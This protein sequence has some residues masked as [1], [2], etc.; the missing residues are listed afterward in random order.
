M[1]R[2]R[3]NRG[4][5][6][7][8]AYV[9]A[10]EVTQ[11]LSHA[12]GRERALTHFRANQISRAYLDCLRTGHIP[13]EDVL[14]AARD[15]LTANG[16]DVAAGLTP[17]RG[18]G[19]GSTHGRHWLCYT[20]DD[21]RRELADVS[22]ATA[23]LFDRIIVDDFLCTQ[24]QCAE[25]RDERGGR[26]WEEFY[27]QLMAEVAREC[28]IDPIKSENPDA[29]VIIKY[30]QWYD[31]FHNFGYDVTRHPTSFDEVWAGTEIRDT[32]VEY[33]VQYQAFANHT[34]LGSL[35]GERMGGAWFD[36]INC[37][38]E[39][40]VE[41]AVQSILAG[42]REL[43]RFHYGPDLY[44]PDSACTAALIEAIPAL[45]ALADELD[46]REPEGVLFYKPPMSDAG[47]EAYLADY[48]GMLGLPIV[49]T[50]VLPRTAEAVCFAAQAAGDPEA[51]T[52]ALALAEGGATVLLT[53]GFIRR[54]A[55]DTRVLE[56]AGLA[57]PGVSPCDVWTYQFAVEGQA[58]SGEQHVRFASRLLPT[59]AEAPATAIH[60][61]GPVAVLTRHAVGQGQVVVLNA[62]TFDYPP[63]SGR[64]T[65]AAPV[66]L[67]GLP[68][69]IVDRLRALTL[70]G[71]NFDVD[72]RSKVGVFRYGDR[73][74]LANFND[75]DVEA[76]VRGVTAGSLL[77][78]P[79]SPENAPADLDG[80]GGTRVPRR[81][82]VLLATDE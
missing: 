28:F 44:E 48:L 39:M 14:V 34:W 12:E 42:A 4:P 35:S 18:S 9:P 1:D 71:T 56:M 8:S 50:H 3:G 36:F 69:P 61:D 72:V 29:T 82:F 79:A 65:S 19:R 10:H 67:T 60:P 20:S 33:V 30:P 57:Y 75:Q 66:S 31:R 80:G 53:P 25:C 55:H 16:I 74:V 13:A 62:A 27:G 68:Q 2:L 38:P 7:F 11:H 76:R 70:S 17:T 51:V 23:R 78:Y 24:C 45:T 73:L 63:G 43:I 77:T 59:T 40:Y 49:P 32:R 37:Y 22:R 64:V 41:Q 81:G 46:G 26:S 21:T 54:L 47:D 58:S 52:R 5:L 15:Y 6:R